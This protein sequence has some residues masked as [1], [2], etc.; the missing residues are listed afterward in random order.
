M[1]WEVQGYDKAHG[2]YRLQ[3]DDN[4]YSEDALQQRTRL[5]YD[6]DVIAMEYKFVSAFQSHKGSAVR[7]KG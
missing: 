2:S 3:G 4:M 7:I 1:S 6:P 5:R